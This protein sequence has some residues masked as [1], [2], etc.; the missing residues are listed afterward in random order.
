MQFVAMYTPD[1]MKDFARDECSLL[2]VLGKR[3]EFLKELP[4]ESNGKWLLRALSRMKV[5]GL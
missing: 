1:R 3:Q 4:I 2:V 5:Y